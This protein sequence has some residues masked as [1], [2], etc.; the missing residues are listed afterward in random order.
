MSD[1]ASLKIRVDGREASTAARDLDKLTKSATGAEA[2][3]QGLAKQSEMLGRTLKNSLAGIAAGLSVGALANYA[4]EL[5]R[6]GQEIDRLSK[7]SNTTVER[8]QAQA[9]AV[10]RAG[11]SSEKYADILKDVQDKVG[12][13]LQTGGGPLKDFFEQI[14]PRVGVTAEQFRR[15]SGPDA[16]QLYV[17]SLEKANISQSE[18]TFYMEALANDSSLLL[19]LLRNNSA[20]L[21]RLSSEAERLGLV[22]DR[23]A[24]E[25]TKRFN[26]ELRRLEL[27]AAVFGRNVALPVI[28]GI[29]GIIDQFKQAR[30][31]SDSFFESLFRPGTLNAADKLKSAEERLAGLMSDRERI[32]R[33][34]SDTRGVDN[35]I[36]SAN[37]DIAFLK[38][39]IARA[40]AARVSYSPDDQSEA[41][42]RRLGLL[43][44]P[45]PRIPTTPKLPRV[46]PQRPR[47]SASEV[48]RPDLELDAISAQFDELYSQLADRQRLAAQVIEETRTPLERLAATESKLISLRKAGLI[49]EETLARARFD[50]DEK[51]AGSLEKTTEKVEE[52]SQ[53]GLQAAERIQG[54]LGDQLF[55]LLDGRFDDI[56]RAFSTMVKRMVAEAAAAQIMDG[57]FGAVN[58]TSKQRGGGILG[59]LGNSLLKFLPSFDGG[60]YTGS[61]SRAGGL[62]GRGGFLAMLHPDEDVLDRTR[63]QGASGAPI[64]I[65]IHN[66]IGNVASQSDVVAGMQVVRSQIL[67]ELQRSAR[68]GGA[69]AA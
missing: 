18:L 27:G 52:L 39:A 56:G 23:D 22:M 64:Q 68:Y 34:N 49:D 67:S 16:L 32:Q 60:G 8:F 2:S 57:L 7:L 21:S 13:F 50:A 4:R 42:A 47:L 38:D 37:K 43:P 55:S 14:A 24:I 35:A 3:A 45:A 17:R 53:A 48:V 65:T 6:T 61:G 58:P 1:V 9:Y 36:A 30:K 19:P 12:D 25:Q 69:L 59:D 28:E 63:G 44:A 31:F 51:Y 10:E 15:L 66:T 41:E 33:A 26:E 40:R 20:E 54:A 5:G 29:N 62:D 11:I 46:A